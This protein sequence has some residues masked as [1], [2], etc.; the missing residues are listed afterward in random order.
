[1]TNYLQR[2]NTARK[3]RR[4][5]LGEGGVP[6]PLEQAQARADICRTCPQNYRGLWLWS[7][8]TALAIAHQMREL[9]KLDRHVKGEAELNVCEPCGCQLKLKVHVP[10]HHLYRHT[11]DETFAKYPDFCWQRKE[12]EKMKG[13]P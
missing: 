8:A 2:I 6:V 9:D 10:F 5:W 7:T 1:M 11:N 3:I 12:L 13:K 4:D